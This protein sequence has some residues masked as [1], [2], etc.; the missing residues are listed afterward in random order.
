M[1]DARPYHTI[2]THVQYSNDSMC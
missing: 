2:I 1:G